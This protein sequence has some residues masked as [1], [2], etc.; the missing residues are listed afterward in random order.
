MGNPWLGQNLHPT[1][2]RR[3]S[4]RHHQPRQRRGLQRLRCQH[5]EQLRQASQRR[6]QPQPQANDHRLQKNA[7]LLAANRGLHPRGQIAANHRTSCCGSVSGWYATVQHTCGHNPIVVDSQLIVCYALSSM[8]VFD[9]YKLITDSIASYLM[10]VAFMFA[11]YLMSSIFI[12]FCTEQFIKIII[13]IRAPI[14][15]QDLESKQQ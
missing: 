13:S 7:T 1:N 5:S 8:N 14:T 11:M 6:S 9:F 3:T 15:R 2:Q 10:F 12:A 4:E